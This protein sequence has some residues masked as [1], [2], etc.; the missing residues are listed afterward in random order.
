MRLTPKLRHEAQ[1]RSIT[2]SELTREAVEHHL[3]GRDRL[4]RAAGAGRSGRDDIAERIEEL[5]TAEVA[6]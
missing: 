3:G 2:V 1:R 4:L 6:K 5:L